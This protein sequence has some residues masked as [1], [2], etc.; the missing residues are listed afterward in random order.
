MVKVLCVYKKYAE[1]SLS[2]IKKIQL[3]FS[4]SKNIDVRKIYSLHVACIRSLNETLTDA[5]SDFASSAISP[6]LLALMY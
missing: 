6:L 1:E 4:L 5:N 2:E 3:L